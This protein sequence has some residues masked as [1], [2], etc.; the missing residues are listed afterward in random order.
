MS[1]LLDKKIKEKKIFK[2]TICIV[3]LIILFYFRS[4][5]FNRLSYV[6]GNLFRPVL[7]LGNNIGEKFKNSISY[8]ISKNSLY[9]ENKNLQSRL[10]EDEIKMLNYDAL[11]G[12]NYS[13]KE[14]L[15][16]EKDKTNMVLSVILSKPNQSIYS[17]LIVDVGVKQEIKIGDL[18]FAL[19]YVPIGRIS[20]VYENSSKVILFSS[21]GE[22]NQGIISSELIGGGGDIFVEVIGR[23]GGNFEMILPRDFILKKGDKVIW[24]GFNP[25]VFALVETTISDLRNPFTKTLLTSP[26]NIQG[27]K[28]VQIEK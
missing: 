16:R 15:G 6:T 17:T 26:V 24:P 27:L 19:G 12:E 14:I 13:L 25:Y 8:F 7:V 21:V 22:K 18:V 10:I 4:G 28:F 9:L 20:D 2:I 3:L 23:G 5:I 1:Y 11:L